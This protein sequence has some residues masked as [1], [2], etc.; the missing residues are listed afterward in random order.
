MDKQNTNIIEFFLHSGKQ[1]NNLSDT[2]SQQLQ[3]L[4]GKFQ[5]FFFFFLLKRK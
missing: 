3:D 1:T 5:D 4:D 2:R